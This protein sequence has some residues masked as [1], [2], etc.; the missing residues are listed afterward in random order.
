MTRV[1]ISPGANSS[2]KKLDFSFPRVMIKNECDGWS[3]DTVTTISHIELPTSTFD[4]AAGQ[5]SAKV[6]LSLMIAI[7]S[8]V[9][10]ITIF[11]ENWH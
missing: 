9:E 2:H 7:G 10:S 1:L 11:R 5:S 6:F 8:G 3:V 4:Y